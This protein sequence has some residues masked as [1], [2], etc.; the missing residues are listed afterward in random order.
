MN[1]PAGAARAGGRRRGSVFKLLAA[2]FVLAAAFPELSEVVP[3]LCLGGT[4]E[5]HEGTRRPSF[6]PVL[7]PLISSAWTRM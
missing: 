4:R 3:G 2:L 6:R 1:V 7:R 5:R